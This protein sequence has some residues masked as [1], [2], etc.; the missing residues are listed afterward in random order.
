ML[1]LAENVCPAWKV[2]INNMAEIKN[3]KK[4][5]ERIKTAIDKG[6]NIVLYG[7]SDLDGVVSV[8]LLQK[9]I[10]TLGGKASCY[11]S[12]R[13]EWG[14]G[15]SVDMVSFMKK[16]SPALLI[17]LDCGI[18]NF[19]GAKKAKEEGF[20]LIIVDHHEP[21]FSLPEA[22]LIV[23]PKQEGEEYPFKEMANAGLAFH[24]AKDLLGEKFSSLSRPFFEL[25]ALATVADMVVREGDNKK[26][27]DEGLPY[28]ENPSLPAFKTLKKKIKE[29]NF[30]QSLVSLLNITKNRG[31]V[32]DAF[33]FLSL[34]EEDAEKMV[35]DLFKAQKE[36]RTPNF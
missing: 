28:L 10:E 29:D 8:I 19:E 2:L 24:I 5:A 30:A 35:E 7:D 18:S 33:I 11:L 17:S 6:E 21:L 36:R 12:N 32:N 15:L 31:A 13:S 25:T 27:L 34:E 14:Y 20:T 26:I 22:H 16:E 23:A 9:S 3:L 1:I 4:T